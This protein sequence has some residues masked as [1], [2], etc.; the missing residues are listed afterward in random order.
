MCANLRDHVL[1]LFVQHLS[2]GHHHA[3]A[4]LLVQVSE[5][6]VNSLSDVKIILRHTWEHDR[7]K[8]I[9]LLWLTGIFL[10]EFL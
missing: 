5:N 1:R 10:I 3:S 9:E 8:T 6:V 4:H 2:I 7:G